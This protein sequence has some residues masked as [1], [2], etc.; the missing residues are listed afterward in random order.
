[1]CGC[2]SA[3]RGA[4]TEPAAGRRTIPTDRPTDR[5][6]P[7]HSRSLSL[8]LMAR[9]AHC[10][11]AAGV[12]LARRGGGGGMFG[13]VRRSGLVVFWSLDELVGVGLECVGLMGVGVF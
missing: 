6:A 11:V 13:V 1:M 4:R 3:E 5:L 10:S 12:V 9:A 8:S 7:T 2:A